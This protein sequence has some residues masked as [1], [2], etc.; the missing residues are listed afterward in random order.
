MVKEY[1]FDASRNVRDL[2][3]YK[4][5]EG[6]T[7]KYG[8]LIRGISTSRFETEHDKKLFES[9]N[10]N[11]IFDFRAKGESECA[12]DVIYNAREYIRRSGMIHPDGSDIDFSPKGMVKMEDI[13]EESSAGMAFPLIK[14]D[15]FKKFYED[16]FFNVSAYG[17]M[18]DILLEGNVPLYYHCS[19]GKDRTGVA[20]ILILLALGVRRKDAEADY[21]YTNI[22]LEDSINEEVKKCEDKI[23]ENPELEKIIR[24]IFGVD[25]ALIKDVMNDIELKYGG[26]AGYFEDIFGLDKTKI[27]R[28]RELYTE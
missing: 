22:C 27:N 26:Y 10:I 16:M 2:G 21:L 9:L 14:N 18:F 20:S 15:V 25:Y 5:K 11:T 7:V 1:G 23:K 3:G 6:K 17:K 12:P 19:A 4:T 24:H 28:L 8:L 13:F